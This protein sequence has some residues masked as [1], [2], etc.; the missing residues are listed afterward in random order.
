MTKDEEAAA[1][2][3]LLLFAVVD[4]ATTPEAKRVTR[5]VAVKSI[6]SYCRW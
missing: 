2:A 3:V 6:V 1:G 4:W 5:A